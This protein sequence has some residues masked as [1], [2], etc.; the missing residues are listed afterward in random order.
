M[1]IH[2]SITQRGQPPIFVPV[3][4]FGLGLTTAATA[5]AAADD[6]ILNGLI[7]VAPNRH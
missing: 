6:L 5:T 1:S 2:K 7:A 3:K 4:A